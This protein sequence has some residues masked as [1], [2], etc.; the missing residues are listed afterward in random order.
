MIAEERKIQRLFRKGCAEYRLLEDGDRILIAL[1]GG[2]DSLELARLLA[3]QQKIYKPRIRVEAAHVVM[4]NIPYETDR[5]YIKSFC[6]S[7]G[8]KL[9]ILHARFEEREDSRKPRCFLCSW[10]RRKTLFGF[11]TAN[12]FN[13]VA[14]GHHQDDILVTLLMNMTFEGSMQTMPP[15]LEMEHFPLTV[16]RPLCL[17]PEHLVKTVAET[18]GFEKQKT[19]CPYEQ[20]TR[21]Q[22]MTEMFRKLEELNPEA[23][24]SLWNSM[25]N[26]H[27]ELLP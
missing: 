15:R 12:G 25:R 6:N 22:S 3:G 11:A 19:A 9:H 16:I 18:E 8:I 17:V 4:D 26:I 1:S 10:T 27:N 5:S 24:Y 14:L 21:R 20:V 7:L 2:K 23:R 13:K